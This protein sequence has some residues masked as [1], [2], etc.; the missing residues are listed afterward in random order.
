[1]TAY[2]LSASGTRI[3]PL[4]KGLYVSVSTWED[5]PKVHIR[6][7]V[8]LKEE[9]DVSS[10]NTTPTGF[11]AAYSPT[12]NSS[13]PLYPT[14]RGVCLDEEGFGKLM[15]AYHTVMEDVAATKAELKKEAETSSAN[16]YSPEMMWNR[17]RACGNE[18]EK[19]GPPASKRRVLLD[20][21]M[22]DVRQGL[23]NPSLYT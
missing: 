17:R 13:A 19:E 6:A 4:T 18:D 2:E 1:M 16:H 23:D 10:H 7:Y 5:Q 21:Q 9:K 3:Y 14:K 15:A 20:R 22:R 11:A 12:E 8:N